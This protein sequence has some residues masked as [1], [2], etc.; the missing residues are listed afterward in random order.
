MML[1]SKKD[2]WPRKVSKERRFVLC[3]DD[4]SQH[5]MVVDPQTLKIRAILD[6]EYAGFYPGYFEG[7]FW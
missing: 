7:P 6:W 4:L 5:N 3:H 1:A 2:D